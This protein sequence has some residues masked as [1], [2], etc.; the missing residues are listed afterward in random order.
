MQR[1]VE[2]AKEARV[3]AIKRNV[4]RWVF[5][6]IAAIAGVLLIAWIGGAFDGDGDEVVQTTP[7]TDQTVPEVVEDTTDLPSTTVADVLAAASDK[8]EV[9][10]PAEIPT[11][12]GVTTLIEGEGDGA[13]NGD[14]V[15]VQYVGVRSVDGVEFDSNFDSGGTFPVV[16][17]QGRVIQGWD[18]GLLGAKAGDRIQ[19]DIPADLAYGDTERSEVIRAGEALTFVIDVVSVTPPPPPVV[20]EQADPSLCPAT[21]GSEDQQQSFDAAPPF[22]ID[23][24]KTYT[25]EI[26][27]NIG[28]ITAELYPQKAPV[29][30]NN[31]VTL[32]RYRYFDETDCHRIIPGFVAQCGSPDGTGTG[33]PGYQIPDELPVP[34]EYVIGS[35]AMANSG[36]DTSGS[37]FFLITGAQGVA[38]P[39]AYSLFGEVIGGLD[40]TLPALDA[41]GNPESNGVPPLSEVIIQSVAITE[42]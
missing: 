4:I 35:L 3:G 39:P 13:N 32:A 30:V 21:D 11:E 38:L 36:P 1:Q 18:L 26:V 29:T 8:P 40:T 5:G 9:E 24:D 23:V 33:S 20:P 27:T 16:L 42:S 31:F 14:T 6:G 12:L 17:G 2:E 10:L 41:L 22:C 7:P 37:Q 28:S 15:E 19:L 25:A 34:G